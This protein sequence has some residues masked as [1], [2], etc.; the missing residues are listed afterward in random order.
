MSTNETSDMPPKVPVTHST[1][2]RRIARELARRGLRLRSVRNATARAERGRYYVHDVVTA[3]VVAW[4]ADLHGLARE[5][6]A[7]QPHEEVVP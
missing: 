5:L 1:L 2:A 7:L 3:R 4:H 6:G